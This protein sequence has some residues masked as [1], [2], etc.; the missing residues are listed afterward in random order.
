MWFRIDGFSRMLGFD[1]MDD[2]PVT[3]TTEWAQH[4]IVLDVPSEATRFFFG[5]FQVGPGATWF[6]DFRFEVVDESVPTTP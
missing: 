2:R 3:G 1:N 5:V 6:D 4:A